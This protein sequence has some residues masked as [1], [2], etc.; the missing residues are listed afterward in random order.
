LQ[1]QHTYTDTKI[2]K[3]K[4]DTQVTAKTITTYTLQNMF[5]SS[6]YHRHGFLSL[7]SY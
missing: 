6:S 5:Y 1:T 3:H 2:P 4:V 7:V